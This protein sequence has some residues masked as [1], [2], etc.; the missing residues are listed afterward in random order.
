[1]LEDEDEELE[2]EDGPGRYGRGAKPSPR[3][4][5]ERRLADARARRR[6]PADLEEPLA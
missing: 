4:E 5:L 6:S 3:E 2:E 1:M